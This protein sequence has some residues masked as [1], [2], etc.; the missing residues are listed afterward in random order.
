MKVEFSAFPK[1]FAG[2]V[3]VFVAAD[4]QLLATA[5]TMDKAAFDGKVTRSLE[6]EKGRYFRGRV[7]ANP[8]GIPWRQ[9][10]WPLGLSAGAV[11]SAW[12][13]TVSSRRAYV[14]GSGGA[15]R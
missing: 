5:Q 1:A 13:R 9:P 2:N 7:S 15:S 8:R 12:R 6:G 3:A 4:K 14:P 11:P 10:S